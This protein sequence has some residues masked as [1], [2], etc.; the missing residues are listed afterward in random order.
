MTP[1]SVIILRSRAQDGI[2]YVRETALKI[3]NEYYRDELLRD[4]A[5]NDLNE[6]LRE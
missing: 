5:A 6:E 3:I 2:P 4:R 1:I